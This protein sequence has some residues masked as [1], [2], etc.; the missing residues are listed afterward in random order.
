ML[1]FRVLL[2][3]LCLEGAFC[4]KY[5]YNSSDLSYLSNGIQFPVPDSELHNPV[6]EEVFQGNV[7][8]VR[9]LVDLFDHLKWPRLMMNWNGTRCRRDVET[10]IQSLQNG[11]YW[12]A[13][14]QYF[15]SIGDN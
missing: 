3:L 4:V 9:W 6:V 15:L 10:Y 14:S 11:T 13:K 2:A 8:E 7:S 5:A 1:E 12:A